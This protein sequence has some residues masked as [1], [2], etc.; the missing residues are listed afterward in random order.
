M[1]CDH[2]TKQYS[3]DWPE[4]ME[5]PRHNSA[6]EPFGF[7]TCP[8]PRN[9]GQSQSVMASL[10]DLPVELL[11]EIVKG[12]VPINPRAPLVGVNATQTTMHQYKNSLRSVDAWYTDDQDPIPLS[13]VSI[14]ADL[15]SLRL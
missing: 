12:L 6:S 1:L 9:C 14:Y 10:N 15:L 3:L 7:I 8:R 11:I 5:C 4:P 2:N 13:S